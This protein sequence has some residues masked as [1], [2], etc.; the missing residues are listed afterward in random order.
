MN[1][2]RT[3][4]VLSALVLVPSLAAQAPKYLYS[5]AGATT[6]AGGVNN[7]IPW[8]AQA[9]SYQQI[10]DYAEMVGVAGGKPIPMIMKGLGFRP[11]GTSTL[12]GRT[13][14]LRLAVGQCPKSADNASATFSSNL[15]KPT[16]G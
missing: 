1:R 16:L 14:E 4:L 10:H 8:W 7:T 5:P 3:T 12:T 9:A 11:A 15:P 13:W 6:Q 2:I